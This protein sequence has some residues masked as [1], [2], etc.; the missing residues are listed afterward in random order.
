MIGDYIQRSHWA[1]NTAFYWM[2]KFDF[3]QKLLQFQFRKFGSISQKLPEK[4][5]V[6]RYLT[7]YNFGSKCLKFLPDDH[8]MWGKIVK[9]YFWEYLNIGGFMPILAQKGA[10]K[11]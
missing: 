3:V 7:P 2:S 4:N 6:L 11:C 8:N 1:W 5:E 9:E 10:E